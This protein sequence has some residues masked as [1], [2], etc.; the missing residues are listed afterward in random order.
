MKIFPTVEIAMDPQGGGIA[1]MESLH[2]KN[3]L[4]EGESLIWPKINQDKPAPTDG[5]A[6]L[7]IIEVINFASAQWT[8]EANHGLRK[9]MEDK[10]IIFPFFDAAS[11]GLS[12]EEDKRNNRTHDTLEDCVMEIEDLKNELAL[13]VISQTQNGRERWDTP[14][15]RSGKKN[16]LRKDRYSALIMANWVGRNLNR[17]EDIVKYDEEYYQNVGFAQGFVKADIGNDLYSGP[18]WFSENMKDVYNNY[19]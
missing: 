18:A 6:G 4:K 11:L 8:S 17:A 1:V 7:H 2:D 13:I 10:A 5:E 16:K 15:T 12:L 14:D 9:D 3:K 19:F